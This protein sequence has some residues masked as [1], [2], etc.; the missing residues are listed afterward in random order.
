M[1]A[2]NQ[3]LIEIGVSANKCTEPKQAQALVQDLE[4]FVEEGKAP[5]EERLQKVSDLAA[6]L[7][8]KGFTNKKQHDDFEKLS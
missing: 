7:Y 1:R 5:Q 4:R 2:G 8:G 6:R 3:L